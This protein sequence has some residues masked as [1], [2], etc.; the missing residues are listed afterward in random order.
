MRQNQ[1]LIR[2]S[3]AGVIICLALS[4]PLVWGQGQGKDLD[5]RCLNCHGQEH[6]T[7]ISISER[8]TMV[9]PPESGLT[10]R[11]NPEGLFIDSDTVARS[12]HNEL[13]CSDCH[14]EAEM[15][16]HPSPLP[17]PQCKGCH[18]E[19]AEAVSRSRHAEVLQRTEP[20]A[21]NCWD[22]H[23]THGILPQSEVNPLDKI[24]ICASCHQTHSGQIEGVENG[25]LLVQSYLDSVHGQQTG[26]PGEPPSVGA[27][28]EDCH[29]QH[30]VLSINDPRSRVHPRN[31][32]ATCGECHPDVYKEFEET[33]HA[34]I[35]S[36]NDPSMKPAICTNCHTAHAI[37]HANTSGFT[38]DLVGEC[39][40][41]HENLYRTYRDTYHGQIVSLGGTRAAR[42]SDCHGTHN[43][44]HP[45]DPLSTLSAANRPDTCARCH[46]RINNLSQTGLLNFIAY[47]PHADFHDKAENP[48]LYY[49]WFMALGVGIALLILWI[50]HWLGWINRAFR[51]EPAFPQ[52]E[53]DTAIVRFK[54]L[55][56][57]A[58][59]AVMCSVFGLILTGLP[60]KFSRQPAIAELTRLL[61]KAEILGFLHRL[62]A[63]VLALV[64]IF[65]FSSLLLAWMKRKKPLMRKVY[66]SSSLVPTL[67]DSKQFLEMLRWYFK[68]G[69]HP[70]LDFWTY[71]EKFDYWAA[72]LILAVLAASG[73]PLWFPV[74]SAEFLSG[75]WIN[76]A[77][78]THSYAGLLLMGI[79]LLIHILN[80]SLRRK[81]FP[82]NTLMFTGQM[83]ESELQLSHSAQYARLSENGYLERLREPAVAGT[84]RKIAI[85]ATL[86]GQL[87]AIGL[88]IMI[89]IA[90]ML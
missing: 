73:L 65:H 26:E 14:P 29:G 27:T 59:S 57:W 77:M 12:A 75:Y 35:A 87:L 90:I 41:C 10:E 82:C 62:F 17:R 47:R 46:E 1:M 74:Y 56:R 54:P 81:G 31:I 86:A 44:R 49:I 3:K 22:C 80:T 79:I 53:A 43:I 19:E 70:N 78:V 18:E 84:K 33:I 89:V 36:R 39:G 37:T 4:F 8:E 5:R 88:I 48:L 9:V 42:C 28:C 30:D 45:E 63:I 66:G 61:V 68:K 2:L 32:P 13:T 21:P 64:A 69:E 6:I 60:L 52:T 38:R 15:L 23:G 25:E 67:T 50:L 55:H 71:T 7:T 83:D 34:D 16:P 11:E 51:E 72:V 76:V 85:Y 58:H 40:S 24:R 20:P